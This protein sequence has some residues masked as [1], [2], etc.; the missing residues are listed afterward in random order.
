MAPK[1]LSVAVSLQVA[2]DR[3][4]GD[5]GLLPIASQEPIIPSRRRWGSP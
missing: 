3:I 5:G 4:D 2:V 1:G